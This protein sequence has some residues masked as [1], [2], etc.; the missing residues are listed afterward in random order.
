MA[1]FVFNIAKGKVREYHDRVA[2]NDP[3]NSAFIV[4]SINTSELDANLIDLDTLALVLAN[5]NTD[6]VA[7]TGYARVVLDNTDIS[8]SSPDDGNDRVDLDFADIDFGAI[9]DDDVDWTDL[10][11]CYDSDTTGGDDTNIIPMIQFDFPIMIDGS[12]VTAQ[13][14]A[15]GY[16]RLT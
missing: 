1:D 15:A 8:A 14:N 4:V 7:N 3:A 2:G 12:S 5:V 6:E 10:L 16:L 9:T 13:L 11:L